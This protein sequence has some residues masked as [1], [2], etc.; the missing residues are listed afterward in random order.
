MNWVQGSLQSCVTSI[1]H[2]SMQAFATARLLAAAFD[3][4]PT[5]QTPD[6]LTTQGMPMLHRLLATDCHRD[7][8]SVQQQMNTKA[9]T[10]TS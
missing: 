9:A 1:P 6:S 2:D 3:S 4:Q 5:A 7:L 8:L 10:N